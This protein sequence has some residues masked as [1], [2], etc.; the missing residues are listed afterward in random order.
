VSAVVLHRVEDPGPG[1]PADAP[2][3]L[4]LGSIGS[5][6]SMW[7]PQVPGLST[8]Y[9]VVRADTR[10][11]GASPVPPAPYEL[12][13][14]V[15][16]AIAVL[17]DLGV[18]RAHVVGLSLGAMTAMRLAARDPERVQRLVVLCTSALFG[19]PQMW[20]DRADLVRAQGMAPV[21]EA[22]V[23]RWVTPGFA[24]TAPETVEALVQMVLAQP[25]E[26]YAACC[27]VIERMDLR[28][29]LASMHAPLLAIAGKQDPATP[30]AALAAIAGGV[31]DGRLLVLEPAAHLANIE[32]GPAVTAAILEHLAGG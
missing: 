23:G 31:P 10:G 6:L 26:G 2:A 3:V 7:D 17:D 12:D 20:A 1:R 29:D 16:D 11:H 30:P 5:S 22:I 9:R 28:A 14:L 21:A 13:D 32:Q 19:P 4:M 27:G 15:D 24:E 25:P 18:E 8:A